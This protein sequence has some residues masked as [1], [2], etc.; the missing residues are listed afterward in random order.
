MMSLLFF[1]VFVAADLLYMNE[2]L[3]SFCLITDEDASVM[4]QIYYEKSKHSIPEMEDIPQFAVNKV[5]FG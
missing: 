1:I 2:D 5:L 3:S 4:R